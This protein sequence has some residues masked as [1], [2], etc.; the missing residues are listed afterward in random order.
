[1]RKKPPLSGWC[2]QDRH[3]R[4]PHL[5]QTATAKRPELHCTC[6]CHRLVRNM[7]WAKQR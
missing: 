4:C 2:E 5:M 3:G 1:M 6:R 7:G